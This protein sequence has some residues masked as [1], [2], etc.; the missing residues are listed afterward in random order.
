MEEEQ[1][2]G[3]TTTQPAEAQPAEETTTTQPAETTTTQPAETTTQPAEVQAEVEVP[4]GVTNEF[5]VSNGTEFVCVQE[6]WLG[7]T[8]FSLGERIKFDSTN[9][10]EIA[11]NYTE[12]FVPAAEFDTR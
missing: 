6:R 5:H 7:S 4:G 1:V 12:Y 8:Q 11:R 9:A 10:E 3:E 2:I